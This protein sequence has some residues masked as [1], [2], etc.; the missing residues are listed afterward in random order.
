MCRLSDLKQTFGLSR[1][2]CRRSTYWQTKSSPPFVSVW[3]DCRAGSRGV[4]FKLRAGQA[5]SAKS[6]QGVMR[7]RKKRSHYCYP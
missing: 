4:G 1:S 6:A 2:F 5:G 3:V 7:Y